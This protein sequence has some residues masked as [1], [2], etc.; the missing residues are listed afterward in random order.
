[1]KGL[2][3]SSEQYTYD[4]PSFT[5][6]EVVNIET[7]RHQLRMVR[8][9]NKGLNDQ[10]NQL[11]LDNQVLRARV[12]ICMSMLCDAGIRLPDDLGK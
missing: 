7:L 1:M 10:V 4:M 8:F 12:S 2:I 11:Q 9:L 6:E 5:E 3:R